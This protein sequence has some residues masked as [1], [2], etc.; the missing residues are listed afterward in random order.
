MKIPLKNVGTDFDLTFN[1][2]GPVLLCSAGLK[3]KKV[4]KDTTYKRSLTIRCTAFLL[5]AKAGG[6]K[7]H[8]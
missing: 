2:C 8:S 3:K 1:E 7:R 4:N 5:S 6:L